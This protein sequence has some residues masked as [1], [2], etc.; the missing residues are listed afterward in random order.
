LLVVLETPDLPH[1]PGGADLDQAHIDNLV[2]RGHAEAAKVAINATD[3]IV[4][5][6]GWTALVELWAKDAVTRASTTPGVDGLDTEVLFGDEL[7][8]TRARNAPELYLA[9]LTTRAA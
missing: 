9:Y 5:R 8:F 7:S 6:E 2:L 1:L 3:P 4:R